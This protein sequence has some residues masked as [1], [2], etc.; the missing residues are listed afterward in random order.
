MG[1]RHRLS[2]GLRIDIAVCPLP[3]FP[4]VTQQSKLA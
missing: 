2:R 1:L 3:Y 4:S